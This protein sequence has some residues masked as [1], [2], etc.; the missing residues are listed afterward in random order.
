[1]LPSTCNWLIKDKIIMGAY[2]DPDKSIAKDLVGLGVKVFVCLQEDEEL[3][4][5]RCYKKQA[6]EAST[7]VE[8]VYFPIKDRLIAN[9][10]TT[11]K[12]VKDLID[13]IKLDN[14]LIY[15]HCFGGH[16]RTGIIAVLLYS[17][18]YEKDVDDSMVYV[19]KMHDSRANT[20]R[21]KNKKYPQTSCQIKQ[22]KRL[23]YQ[24]K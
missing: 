23:C 16:G 24:K 4:A 13:R 3:K 7:D 12:F 9:D 6:L 17:H 21:C 15:I 10:E 22:V 19:Q 8:F 20:G 11:I 18:M 2:P 14:D 5:F 1:M